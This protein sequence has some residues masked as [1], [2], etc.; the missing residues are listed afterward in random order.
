M[1]R[2]FAAAIKLRRHG[3]ETSGVAVRI[4]AGQ[5]RN[6]N[7]LQA[8][9]DEQRLDQTDRLDDRAGDPG[10]GQAARPALHGSMRS[11]GR[12]RVTAM[13]T[14]IS[15]TMAEPAT[16]AAASPYEVSSQPPGAANPE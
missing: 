11:P 8:A 3:S 9:H 5:H 4:E 13:N 2:R 16:A 10:A 15:A 7:E 12:S 1:L 14:K 6:R